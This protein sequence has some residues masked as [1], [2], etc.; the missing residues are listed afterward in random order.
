MPRKWALS[1]EWVFFRHTTAHCLPSS[2]FWFFWFF[3]MLPHKRLKEQQQQ[4]QPTPIDL[5]PTPQLDL[6]QAEFHV[7]RRLVPLQQSEL[8]TFVMTA[9]IEHGVDDNPPPEFVYVTWG[10]L[11]DWDVHE[12]SEDP[13]DEPCAKEGPVWHYPRDQG[14]VHSDNKHGTWCDEDEGYSS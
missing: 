7:V 11:F 14:P 3:V 8:P 5:P 2:A 10:R 6:T 4:Q 9:I 1:K 13:T 12:P